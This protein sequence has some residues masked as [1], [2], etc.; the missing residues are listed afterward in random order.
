[1]GHTHWQAPPGACRGRKIRTR[2]DTDYMAIHWWATNNT[3]STQQL[4]TLAASP[5]SSSFF[6]IS[7]IIKYT[8]G[9]SSGIILI[10]N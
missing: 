9:N 4:L 10:Y 3:L 7:I 1:M 6:A 8:C 5:N 2:K